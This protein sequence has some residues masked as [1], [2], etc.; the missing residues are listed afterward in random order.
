MGVASGEE[1]EP[2]RVEQRPA[3]GRQAEVLER[4][5][6]VQRPGG[7]EQPVPGEV[8]GVER[9]AALFA[10]PGVERVQLVADA[11]SL[12]EEPPLRQQAAFLGEEQEDHLHHHRDGGLV[13]VIPGGGQ[14]V[15]L[16]PVAGVDGR[17]GHR[18]HQ[19]LDRAP[20]LGAERLG[21]LLGGGDRLAEQLRQQVLARAADQ[22]G[23]AQQLDEGVAG[24]GRLDPRLGV[25]DAGGHHGLR[26][27]AGDRPPAAV[28][29]HPYR[30]SRG[31]QQLFHPVDRTGRPAI[32]GGIP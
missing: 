10:G 9:L 24:G 1:A 25:D 29:D 31:P 4:R 3:V 7:G 27:R 16:T 21:D 26:A 6:T 14:R 28:R 15:R 23:K 12:G 17:L 2:G 13:D 11:V 19:Q 20:D 5:A 32:A 22:A 8:R 30:D 18:L